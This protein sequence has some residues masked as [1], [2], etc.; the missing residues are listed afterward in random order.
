MVLSWKWQ[1]VDKV[2]LTN[3]IYDTQWFYYSTRNFYEKFSPKN[4]NIPK[5]NSKSVEKAETSSLPSCIK[6]NGCETI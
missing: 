6:N 4:N 2:W 5:K 3:Y 1:K